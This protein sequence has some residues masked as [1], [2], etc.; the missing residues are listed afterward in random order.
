MQQ[1]LKIRYYNLEYLNNAKYEAFLS[2]PKDINAVSKVLFMIIYQH[3]QTGKVTFSNREIS[4]ATNITIRGIQYAL[5]QLEAEG[6]ITRTFKDPED[7]IL[8]REEI[9]LNEEKA[10][11]YLTLTRYDETYKNSKKRG[12]L[13]RLINQLNIRFKGYLENLVSEAKKLKNKMAIEKAQKRSKNYQ[14]HLKWHLNKYNNYQEIEEEIDRDDLLETLKEMAKTY[15]RLGKKRR[16][17]Q[18]N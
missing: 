13:R 18:A 17:E 1:S 6:I 12:L 3:S 4:N 7:I 8:E 10:L 15:Y 5:T 11:E 16:R 2:A 9:C 14:K